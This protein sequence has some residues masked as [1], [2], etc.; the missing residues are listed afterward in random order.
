MGSMVGPAP[1]L[2]HSIVCFN[3]FPCVFYSCCSCFC[4]SCFLIAGIVY[5]IVDV[6]VAFDA[7]VPIA[8]V[9]DDAVASKHRTCNITRSNTSYIPRRA[10]G[11]TG[12]RQSQNEDI[13]RVDGVVYFVTDIN[14]QLSMHF[15]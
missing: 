13:Y 2:A 10:D 14:F 11:N 15:G 9:V 8:V 5:A 7:D 3:R 1:A 12:E 6:D 4:R